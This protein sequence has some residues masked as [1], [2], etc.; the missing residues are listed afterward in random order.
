MTYLH[1]P[2]RM[3]TVGDLSIDAAIQCKIPPG[4]MVQHVVAAEQKLNPFKRSL[5]VFDDDDCLMQPRDE[6]A[7]FGITIAHGE[8]IACNYQ[9]GVFLNWAGGSVRMDVPPTMTL[10]G[11]T[12]NGKPAS[13]FRWTNPDGTE[14]QHDKMIGWGNSLSTQA[15]LG[16]DSEREGGKS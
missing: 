15:D 16:W 7:S 13:S 11:C 9:Y 10:D 5:C 1:M 4:T 8:S 2:T 14:F 12:I 6:I 3:R